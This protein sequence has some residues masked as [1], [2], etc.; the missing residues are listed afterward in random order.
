MSLTGTINKKRKKEREE[1]EEE[2][3]R[4][5]KLVFSPDVQ[6][7]EKSKFL[8]K[9]E[10]EREPEGRRRYQLIQR[11]IHVLSTTVKGCRQDVADSR[12]TRIE[13]SLSLFHPRALP[14]LHRFSIY[15]LAFRMEFTRLACKTTRWKEKRE[16]KG[17][18]GVDSTSVGGV[19]RKRKRRRRP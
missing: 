3:E 2:E 11:R 7:F 15:L 19:G 5:K 18:K 14:F 10:R 4:R 17:R 12:R 9:R 1:E 8:L 6:P 16:R 13:S